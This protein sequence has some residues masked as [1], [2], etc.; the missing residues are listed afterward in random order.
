[1]FL[2][3]AQR[4]LLT[5]F[6]DV[7]YFPFWWYTSGVVHVWKWT[8][9]VVAEGNATFA[10]GVWLKNLFVPMFGQYD[11]QGRLVSFFMRVM[12][13]IIRTI[14]LTIWMVLAMIP[15]ISWF[16]L[17]VVVSYFFIRSITLGYV[18]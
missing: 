4:L 8:L 18:R 7:V 15:L 14:F 3:I 13:V 16:V 10:P 11:F 1:M 2:L 9:R 17:P 6:L 5:A 12:N